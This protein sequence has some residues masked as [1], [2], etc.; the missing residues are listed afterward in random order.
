MPFTS[1]LRRCYLVSSTGTFYIV[2]TLFNFLTL[3]LALFHYYI[4]FDREKSLIRF[5]DNSNSVPDDHLGTVIG[6]Y[7]DIQKRLLADNKR[8]LT[9]SCI[10]CTFYVINAILSGFILFGPRYQNYTTLTVFMTNII[11]LLAIFKRCMSQSYD[12][13]KHNYALSLFQYEPVP[14]NV[15]DIDYID[16]SIDTTEGGR[17]P[18]GTVAIGSEK[19]VYFLVSLIYTHTHTHTHTYIYIFV[20]VSLIHVQ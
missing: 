20:L 11:C 18:I 5:L 15:I 7:P 12:G 8:S 10:F 3:I 6:V 13:I 2:A 1:L 16:T 14:Y 4:I 19:K 17:F 9:S